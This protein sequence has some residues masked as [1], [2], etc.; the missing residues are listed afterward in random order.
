V[1]G[2]QT[3]ALP[4]LSSNPLQALKQIKSDKGR[5]RWLIKDE[6]KNLLETARRID[7]PLES[8][9]LFAVMTGFRKGNLERV[10]ARDVS[11][12]VITALQTKSG[13]AYDVPISPE[14]RLLLNRLP[15]KGLLLDTQDLDRR[16]RRV[17]KEAGLYTGEGDPNNITLHVLRHTF[18]SYYVQQGGELLK[19][20]KMMGHAGL[21]M[22]ERYAHL[23]Q[24]DLVKESLKLDFGIV[25]QVE[26]K[27]A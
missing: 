6:L 4:I 17:V 10:T 22:T 14:L 19:L 1:T 21:A 8:V 27:I 7:P 26:L 18:A 2:V 11:E 5:V 9:I 13:H 16:F 24:K 23:A 25:P 15:K 12:D 3:C 20:Q